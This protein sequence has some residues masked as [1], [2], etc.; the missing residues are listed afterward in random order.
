[1]QIDS[2]KEFID[3]I[4]KAKKKGQPITGIDALIPGLDKDSKE[5]QDLKLYVESN[6][7]KGGIAQVYH[8]LA[9]LYPKF[10][11][12]DLVNWQLSSGDPNLS[13]PGY[14]S[15][16]EALKTRLISEKDYNKIVDPRKMIY[17]E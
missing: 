6:G 15:F 16:H 17:P 5:W 10:S 3:G 4:I 11:V 14:S 13:L 8:D 12:E 7:L 1:M 9:R 2:H